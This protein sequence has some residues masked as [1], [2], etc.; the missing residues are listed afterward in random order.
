MKYQRS[1]IVTLTIPDLAG[2]KFDK[3]GNVCRCQC[4]TQCQCQSQ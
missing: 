3:R 2:S 4:Q 1:T